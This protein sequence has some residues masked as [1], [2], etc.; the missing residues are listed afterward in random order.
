MRKLIP[1]NVELLAQGHIANGWLYSPVQIPP[2]LANRKQITLT[3]LD[4]PIFWWFL[5]Y[6]FVLRLEH[7]R[8]VRDVDQSGCLGL[9]RVRYHCGRWLNI[10]IDVVCWGILGGAGFGRLDCC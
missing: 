2:S 3:D 1:R 10:H 8:G 7:W 9:G 6:R 5:G 4:F